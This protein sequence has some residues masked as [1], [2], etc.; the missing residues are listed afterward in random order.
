MPWWMP[1]VLMIS[2]I[3][4]PIVSTRAGSKVAAQ[5]K[6][7]G[8]MVACQAARPVRISSCTWAGMPNRFAAITARWRC[9]QRAHALA[10]LDRR[11]AE[12][13][14]ELS[15]P[16]RDGLLPRLAAH[17]VPEHGGH[18]SDFGVDAPQARQLGDLLHEGH[19]GHQVTDARRHRDGRVLPDAQRSGPPWRRSSGRRRGRGGPA[20]HELG[21]HGHVGLLQHFAADQRGRASRSHRDPSAGWAA[22]PW[23]AACQRGPTRGCCRT[24]PPRGCSGTSTPSSAATSRVT[25]ADRSLAAKI[26]VGGRGAS[27]SSRA[28]TRAGSGS[29]APLRSS[30]SSTARPAASE[31][32]AVALLAPL[33]R[34]EVGPTGDHAD[35]GVPKVEQV[36]DAQ[37]GPLQVVGRHRREARACRC[38]GRPR[39][40]AR[41]TG[42]LSPSG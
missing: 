5:H 26:A 34:D 32:F 31:R 2:P 37:P 6:G 20:D 11:G 16:V 18:L 35:A 3:R 22:P 28:A 17:G 38:A 24:R 15:Q 1:R 21:V 13:P 12:R 23:S 4:A 36:S 30:A 29:K 10:R 19:P 9:G 8:K 41:R 42:R 33:G 7:E 39:R 40:S 25:R 14:G 27:S